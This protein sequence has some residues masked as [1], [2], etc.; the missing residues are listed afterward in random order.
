MEVLDT[1]IYNFLL[2]SL[3]VLHMNIRT[4]WKFELQQC[5]R[6][7]FLFLN[8]T[9]DL[10]FKVFKHVGQTFNEHD[11]ALKYCPNVLFLLLL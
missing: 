5:L 6:R 4:S 8:K 7:R 3:R 1:N 9:A 10:Y 11:T 2:Q